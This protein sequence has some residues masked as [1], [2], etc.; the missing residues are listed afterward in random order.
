M[1]IQT[2]KLDNNVI[3][4]PL[5]GFSDYS[6]RILARS[7]GAGI[8]YSEMISVEGLKRDHE[9]TF[10]YL[11]NNEEAKPYGIQLFGHEPISFKEAYLAI[12]D[13]PF[14]LIDINAG[15]PV[16]KV[17]KRGSGSALMKTPDTIKAIIYEIRNVYTGPLTIK[18]R[19]GWGEKTINA[20][21][22]AKLAEAEGVNAVTI[23]PRTQTLG[24]KGKADWNI[25]KDVKEAVSIPVI[26]NGDVRSYEDIDRMISET[27]C[28][29]VMIGRAALAKPWLFSQDLVAGVPAEHLIFSTIKKHIE[30]LQKHANDHQ[31]NVMIRKFVPKYIKGLRGN[32]EL[33]RQIYQSKSV[34]EAISAIEEF[35]SLSSDKN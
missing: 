27:G 15:C 11:Y 35:I 34:E 10:T 3:A 4:A 22:I 1:E 26:G 13:Y 6:W 18:I 17:V 29:G 12:K 25:I 14:D 9:K 33:T 30:L 7:F 31:T 5:A 32:K 21:E 2:L 16:K 8:V 23:H 28:D 24:F 20:V 19:S